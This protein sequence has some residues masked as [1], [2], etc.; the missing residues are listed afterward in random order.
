MESAYEREASAEEREGLVL[1]GGL[2]QIPESNQGPEFFNVEESNRSNN[3]DEAVEQSAA[4]QGAIL[5]VRVLHSAGLLY[6][7]QGVQLAHDAGRNL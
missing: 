3:P 2:S 6:F 5:A 7:K 4:V 1:V